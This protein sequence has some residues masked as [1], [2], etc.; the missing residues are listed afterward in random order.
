MSDEIRKDQTSQDAKAEREPDG[1]VEQG[2]EE[3]GEDLVDQVSDELIEA[4]T[5]TEE[6][7]QE[8]EETPEGEEEVV[9][10]EERVKDEIEIQI[11]LLQ[12]ADWVVR[13]EAVITLG[14]MGDERCV[15]PVLRAL[16]DGDWQ[17]RE[18]GIEACGNIGSPAVDGLLR[19]L[20]DWDV[21]RYAI[22]AMG[23]IKDERVLDPLVQQLRSDEFK[24]FATDALV[25]LGQPAVEKLLAAL[26]DKDEVVRKQAIIALGQ[27]KDSSSLDA[28]IE[29]LQ[30]KDWF[31]RIQAAAAIEAIHDDRG[32][33]A[34]KAL[35]KDSDEV[36]RMRAER[37]IAG[38][39]RRPEAATA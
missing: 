33:D 38:W 16:R 5:G 23:K 14:E 26:K 4:P 28:L 19:L 11:D 30:D 7:G 32:K 13:R 10:E 12:D 22:A 21:R 2:H 25:E 8:A 9:L 34:I 6:E 27:I 20:R 24:E 29:M 31:T 1:A 39:K 15:E 17:V 36:V 35:L 18:V 3:V 37:I